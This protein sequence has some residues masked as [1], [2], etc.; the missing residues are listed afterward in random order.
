MLVGEG[1]KN[2]NKNK[3]FEEGRFEIKYSLFRDKLRHKK[4]IKGHSKK[5]LKCFQ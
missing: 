3:Y 5:Q 2:D 1:A 4:N